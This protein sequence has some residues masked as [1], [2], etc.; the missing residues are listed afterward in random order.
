M[1]LDKNHLTHYQIEGL[2][3]LFI[4]KKKRFKVDG[5]VESK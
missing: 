1:T 4:G 2:Q 5:I 3:E